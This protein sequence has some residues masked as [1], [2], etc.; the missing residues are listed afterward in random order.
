MINNYQN[1][2]FTLKIS[3][4][5]NHC[6][7]TRH[8]YLIDKPVISVTWYNLFILLLTFYYGFNNGVCRKFE[9]HWLFSVSLPWNA[10][11]RA[12]S[13]LLIN[14]TVIHNRV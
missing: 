12:S 10:D 4:C 5:R 13:T 14:A 6:I 9:T 3:V 1:S 2:Q 7:A 8:V 11:G